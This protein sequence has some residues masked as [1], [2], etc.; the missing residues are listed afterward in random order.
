MGGGGLGERENKGE[1]D[2]HRTSDFLP[3]GSSVWT[4]G[5]DIPGEGVY[6]SCAAKL[7]DSE[8][9]VLG[10]LYNGTQAR[11]YSDIREKWTEWPSLTERVFGQSC[12]GLGDSVLMVGGMN[13]TRSKAA[14]GRTVI[15]ETKTGSAR[16]VASL[17]YPRVIG[18]MALYRGKPVILGG[19]ATSNDRGYR[20]DG[21]MW[22]M[23]TET[24]EEADIELKTAK[25]GLSLVT[26]AEEIDCD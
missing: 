21:E 4:Q 5:P 17:K 26:V 9:V 2:S 23:D 22:N 20:S 19:S 12:V 18:G 7:S 1:D 14:T 6:A 10:G 25:F 11:V 13:S 24:W 15:F 3:T 16:E 8:F